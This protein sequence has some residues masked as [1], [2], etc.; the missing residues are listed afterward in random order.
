M[1]SVSCLFWSG[2]PDVTF[3]WMTITFLFFHVGR[4]LWRE[5]GSVICSAMTLVQFQVI[6]RPTVCRPVCLG[7]RPHFFLLGVRFPHPYPPWTGWSSPKSKSKVSVKL[8]YSKIFNVTIGRA[9]CSATWNLGT[10]SAFALGPRKSTENLDRVGWS[11]DLPDA[12]W[13]LASSPALNPWALTLVP[14]CAVVF[15][16]HSFLTSFL[17]V[18]VMFIWFG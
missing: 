3:L 9:A 16:F 15:S 5:D 1:V 14:L 10:N 12:N 8:V 11:Q 13:L 7:A 17:T 4:P 6:M 18:I 2:W